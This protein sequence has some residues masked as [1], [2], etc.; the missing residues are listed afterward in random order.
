M[1]GFVLLYHVLPGGWGSLSDAEIHSVT[2]TVTMTTGSNTGRCC[3][4]NARI[5]C[6]LAIF[7]EKK[8]R[9]DPKK[10]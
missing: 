8:T 2:V 1:S 4:R 10:F 3:R 6:I 9:L 7:W 5:F